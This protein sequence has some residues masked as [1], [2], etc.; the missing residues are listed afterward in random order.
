ML[1]PTVLALQPPLTTFGNQLIDA[2]GVPVHLHCIAWSGAHEKS[3]LTYGIENQ[4]LPDLVSK[5]AN[6]GFNCVRFQFS[7]EL[8]RLN[9][10][11]DPKL[12][13]PNPQLV[14]KTGL[15][16]YDA[17]V[18]ELSSKQIMTILDYH[19]MDAVVCCSPLD[20]NGAWFNDR[21]SF[22]QV[23]DLM[24]AMVSRHKSNP[25]VI[26]IDLRNE[27]RP[28][29]DFATIFGLSVPNPL[30]AFL[31]VWGLGGK[32]DWARAAEQLGNAALDINPDLLI[33]VQGFYQI[34]LKEVWTWFRH[35][36]GDSCR[37]PRIPQVIKKSFIDRYPVTLNV[38]NRLV[39]SCHTYEFFHD[40]D[41]FNLTY[42][43]WKKEADLYWGD[44]AKM[45]IPF[46]LGEFGVDHNPTAVHSDFFQYVVR[47]IEET[48]INWAYWSFEG[49]YSPAPGG[50]C[51]AVN[52]LGYPEDRTKENGY[53]FL[54]LD[55]NNTAS[56]DLLYELKRIM[57]K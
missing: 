48:K 22:D 45:N 13:G 20:E 32:W 34:Q 50:F 49:T 29:I 36:N 7:A 5:I 35:N 12:L 31:P 10:I 37:K 24:Q 41:Y 53:G 17:I 18:Q 23:R 26:G 25:W 14:N 19:Q 51:S 15:E 44:V 9:P 6:A 52:P 21:Y 57:F 54:S 42:E 55:Y 3:Y 38:K 30:T 11:I 39:Y 28:M 46:F 47:Y 2:Q 27:I 1:F 16:I 56:Q 8:V 43:D 33:I 4:P 40:F